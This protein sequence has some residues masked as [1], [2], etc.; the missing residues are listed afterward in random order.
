MG[1]WKMVKLPPE[2]KQRFSA[3]SPSKKRSLR[4]LE[5]NFFNG[6]GFLTRIGLG[7]LTTPSTIFKR[8]VVYDVSVNNLSVATSI[9]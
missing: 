8:G 6:F 9:L 5:W 2:W 7:L 3:F 4:S 1:V